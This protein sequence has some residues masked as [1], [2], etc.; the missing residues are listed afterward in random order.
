MLRISTSIEDLSKNNKNSVKHILGEY[1]Q[2]NERYCDKMDEKEN[3]QLFQKA[4]DTGIYIYIEAAL[5][6]VIQLCPRLIDDLTNNHAEMFMSLLCK[7][8]SGKRLNLI[9]R[10]SFET[11]CYMAALQY[12]LGISW[13]TA[14]WEN[15]LDFNPGENLK[16]YLR[17][18]DR[19]NISR[20]M[21]RKEEPQ[22]KK[23]QSYKK[24]H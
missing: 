17:Q 6:R 16:K 3:D 11:R 20:K 10:G 5:D 24:T 23:K 19:Q 4:E 12:N 2:C 15:I 18:R 21:R 1:R 8:Q 14:P 7:Y 13:S 22:S 9:Q